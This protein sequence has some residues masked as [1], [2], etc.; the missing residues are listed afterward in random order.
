MDEIEQERQ[1]QGHKEMVQKFFAHMQMVHDTSMA[2][3]TELHESSDLAPIL[4]EIF[5]TMLIGIMGILKDGAQM[6]ELIQ[7]LAKV[8]PQND[9]DAAWLEE[10]LGESYDDDG[11]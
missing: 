10:Q 9:P 2:L 6:L 5:L 4:K 8:P 3:A 7:L 1:A 11:D